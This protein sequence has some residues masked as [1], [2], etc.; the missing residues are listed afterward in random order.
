LSVTQAVPVH[1]GAKVVE[2]YENAKEAVGQA[3]QDIEIIG[4]FLKVVTSLP[5]QGAAKFLQIVRAALGLRE[6][7]EVELDESCTAEN[8]AI[9]SA[10]KLLFAVVGACWVWFFLARNR[11][12]LQRRL[13]MRVSSFCNCLVYLPCLLP[14]C[15]MCATC[16][17]V[18]AVNARWE[19]NNRKPIQAMQPISADD[20]SLELENGGQQESAQIVNA[21]QPDSESTALETQQGESFFGCLNDVDICLMAV[22]CPCHLFGETVAQAFGGSCCGS[23]CAFMITAALHFGALSAVLCVDYDDFMEGMPYSAYLAMLAFPWLLNFPAVLAVT[24]RS[25]RAILHDQEPRPGCGD[26]L[27]FLPCFIVPFGQCALAQ[28]ARAVKRQWVANGQEP[29]ARSPFQPIDWKGEHEGEPKWV[30]RPVMP[31]PP[32]APGTPAI[33]VHNPMCGSK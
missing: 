18:R 22:G 26:F 2:C 30:A 23:A 6:L 1:A 25:I 16:Q 11:G 17:E 3:E 19:R 24:R 7:K 15:G 20:R 5:Q 10:L 29:L 9:W 4:K 31:I 13:G 8:I 12:Q 27:L 21:S 33:T 14:V 32:I 28:Q